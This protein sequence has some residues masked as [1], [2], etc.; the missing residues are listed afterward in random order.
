MGFRTQQPRRTRP[1]FRRPAQQRRVTR[2]APQTARPAAAPAAKAAPKAT[3]PQAT[4]PKPA[5]AK[6][7]TAKP[8]TP[9]PATTPTAPARQDAPTAKTPAAAT[10][11]QEPG[12]ANA[13]G[14]F[15]AFLKN[16]QNKAQ[17]IAKAARPDLSPQQRDA[18][19]RM[20]TMLEPN[21]LGGNDRTFNFGDVDAV[22]NGLLQDSRGLGRRAAQQL[23]A[24]GQPR[25]ANLVEKAMN[26]E[27]GLFK[28]IARNQVYQQAPGQIRGE[29]NR[30]LQDARVDPNTR[31]APDR[32]P[33]NLTFSEIEQFQRDA[34]VMQDYQQQLSKRLGLDVQFP[35][36]VSQASIDHLLSG[37]L[38]I[39]PGAVIKPLKR[40]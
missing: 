16:L 26:G 11:A 39:P 6:P 5:T 18:A 30:G 40:E 2:S 8:N 17:S 32:T 31:Q 35:G 21:K 13:N 22:T 10:P 23:R 24:E 4:T 3:T 12:G 15:G 33:R 34:K 20:R 19:E 27:R 1:I 28:R 14:G 7:A 36:G 38:G 37:D 25:K 9:K 29:L